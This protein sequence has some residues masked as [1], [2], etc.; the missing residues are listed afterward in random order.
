MALLERGAIVG[1]RIMAASRSHPDIIA[2]G[3]SAGG[4]DAVLNLVKHLPANLPA[5]VLIVLHRHPYEVSQL[6]Q[7][8]A[9]RTKLHVAIAKTGDNLRD[10]HCLIG[11]P[12]R[13]L[14]IGP[15]LRVQLL[16]DG[17]YRAHNIDALFWSLALHAP[18]H[19]IGIILSGT[20]KDGALGLKA[21]KDA[22]GIVFVQSPEEAEF[23]DMPENAISLDGPI[24]LVAPVATLAREI[25][26]RVEDRDLVPA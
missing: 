11:E 6:Q 19:T 8:L 18:R 22:G 3:A 12:G 9:H 5:S 10:G 20:M 1:K 4:V 21:I 23:E 26:R 16:P 14:I 7:V 17:F 2:I 25:I 13:H 15:D 24:D